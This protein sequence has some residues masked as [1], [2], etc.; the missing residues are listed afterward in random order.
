MDGGVNTKQVATEVFTLV[1]NFNFVVNNAVVTDSSELPENSGRRAAKG[2]QVVRL[3]DPGERDVETRK[4]VFRR[5]N[6]GTRNLEGSGHK[7]LP[8]FK[9]P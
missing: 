2:F 7:G 8:D 9:W 6:K 1:N 4:P 5:K 3:G